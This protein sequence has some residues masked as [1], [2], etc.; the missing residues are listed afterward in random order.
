MKRIP[1]KPERL[2]SEKTCDQHVEK[3]QD[4]IWPQ[5]E[6]YGRGLWLCLGLGHFWQ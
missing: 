1:H 6:S 2:E 3:E 4:E 5:E